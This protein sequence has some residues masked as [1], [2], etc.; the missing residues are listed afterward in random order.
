MLY[1]QWNI[2]SLG[3]DHHLPS[4]QG[5]A[6][7]TSLGVSGLCPDT[8]KYHQ[9]NHSEQHKSITTELTSPELPSSG[10]HNLCKNYRGWSARWSR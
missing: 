4:A 2:N 1:L 9:Q 5:R 6:L 7:Q 10:S 8:N 3:E